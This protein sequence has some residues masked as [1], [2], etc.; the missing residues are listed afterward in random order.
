M[1]STGQLIVFEGL[2]GAGKTSVSE[3][4]VRALVERGC[5]CVYLRKKSAEVA[6]GYLDSQLKAMAELIWG[7]NEDDP[8]DRLGDWHWLHK[9][10][11]Y[12]NALDECFV[13]PAL[14]QGNIVI[15][16]NWYFKFLARF[17]QKPKAIAD[18]AL[19]CLSTVRS[20]NLVVYLKLSPE[21]AAL[22]KE[23][24]SLGESGYMD[25]MHGA[26]V[27]NFVTYQERISKTMDEMAT[28]Q[29]WRTVEASQSQREVV[30]EV[31]EQLFEYI[32][33]SVQP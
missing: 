9:M 31:V 23:R 10:T 27:S 2:D 13:G 33:A 22:R 8:I 11:S 7:Y 20:P 28:A 3:L 25:G 19:A 4:V 15:A 30:E 32:A 26:T 12:F 1:D 21:I 14:E 24:F 5:Q 17:A 18:H 6:N 29:G 16:D